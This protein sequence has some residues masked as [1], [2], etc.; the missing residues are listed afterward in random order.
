FALARPVS[1]PG[2]PAQILTP[3]TPCTHK[4]DYDHKAASLAASFVKNFTQYADFANDEI[5]NA[6]PKLAVNA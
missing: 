5:M 6:A 3:R 1:G 2:V 4:H